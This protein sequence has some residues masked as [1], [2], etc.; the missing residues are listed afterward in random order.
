MAGNVWEWTHSLMEEYPYQ[1]DDGREDGESPGSRVLRGGSFFDNQWYARCA[2]RHEYTLD[3]FLYAHIG[4]RVA[5]AP[6][7]P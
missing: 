7:I 5:I 6:S 4:F 3:F 1:H 2:Y